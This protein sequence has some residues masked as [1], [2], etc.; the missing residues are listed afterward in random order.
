[1]TASLPDA[2]A[3]AGLGAREAELARWR[4]R[5]SLT[6]ARYTVDR[7]LQLKRETVSVVLPAREVAETLGPVLDSLAPL[8]RSGLVDELIVVDAASRDGTAAV[9]RERGAAVVQESELL[10][11]YGR[12]EGKGDAMWRGLAATSGEI[13]VYL[14]T[15]TRDFAERFLLGMVGPLL[16]RPELELVKGTFRR[17]LK[18]DGVAVPDGGGRVTEL[19]ARPLLNLFM[20]E[21][22]GFGQPLAG[23]TAAR[24]PLLESLPYPV[25]YGV[26]IAMMIDVARRVGPDAMAQVD[27]GTRQNR[28]QSLR[29]LSAMALA[30]V[31]AASRR[32]GL[33]PAETSAAGIALPAGDGM[34]MRAVSLTERPP[35][36][37]VPAE[38]REAARAAAAAAVRPLETRGGFRAVRSR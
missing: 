15:D 24:R 4:E 30:V 20:P 18:L 7:L 14:D 27:L 11:D 33:G 6:A 37:S 25:G 10:G 36:E 5:N 3:G 22:G 35:L 34:E 23:E 1:L 29:N 32:F 17:P 2:P 26:E 16:E 12:A 31:G 38:A 21:L 9:A 28:H 19:V 13:V 8:E